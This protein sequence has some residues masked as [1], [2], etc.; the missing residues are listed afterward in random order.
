[1]R[2][3]AFAVRQKRASRDRGN[4]PI[5]RAVPPVR[6]ARC[7]DASCIRPSSVGM[8]ADRNLFGCPSIGICS[9]AHRSES[10]RMSAGHNRTFHRSEAV[11]SSALHQPPPLRR[12][13]LPLSAAFFPPLPS[14]VNTA[15]SV[16]ARRRERFS[17]VPWFFIYR[18]Y[19]RNPRCKRCRHRFQRS[20]IRRAVR[21]DRIR[22]RPQHPERPTAYRDSR[23]VRRTLSRAPRCP[24]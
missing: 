17:R 5:S 19:P 4:D 24:P 15:E 3:G 22:P 16:R 8:P 7:A 13:L 20:G 2:R 6:K 21:W 9:D 12:L 11:R 1:M 10:V 18:S 14:T 23:T